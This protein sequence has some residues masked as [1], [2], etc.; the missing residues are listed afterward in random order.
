[1]KARSKSLSVSRAWAVWG[2]QGSMLPLSCEKWMGWCLPLPSPSL[3]KNQEGLGM[4]LP[5]ISSASTEAPKSRSRR[6]DLSAGKG[7]LSSHCLYPWTRFDAHIKLICCPCPH[8]YGR[9]NQAP[10]DVFD[11]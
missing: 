10:K 8:K 5:L 9:L 6:A 11:R 7:G 3:T 1:M 2:N 4:L